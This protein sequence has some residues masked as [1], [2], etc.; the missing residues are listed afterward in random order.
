MARRKEEKKSPFIIRF[1]GGLIKKSIAFL[2]LM[3]IFIGSIV[4]GLYVTN[5]FFAPTPLEDLPYSERV[6]EALMRAEDNV[7]FLL[8]GS[9][10]REGEVSRSDTMI[11]MVV[12]PKDK[13]IAYLSFPRD[14]L[15]SIEGYGEDKLNHAY[16]YGGLP[17]LESTIRSNF[18]AK[19]DYT[20]KVDFNS[21]KKVI[22]AMGGIT[23]DVESD[24]SVPW[25]EIDL[26]KGKQVLNGHDALGYV[27]WRSDG[28]GDLGRIERQQKF[29]QAVTEKL[30]HMM[31]WTAVRVLHTIQSEIET[32]FSFKEM[33]LL[34]G[35][36]VGIGKD[37]IS[38]LS[39]AVEPITIGG[40]S[41][42]R[43]NA[44]NVRQVLEEADYGMVLGD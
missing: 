17:L 4:G 39:F 11:Y 3:A 13:K 14:T 35:R 1:F 18:H 21:F 22:D 9:D 42:V 38:H 27:R 37:D 10:E 40:I 30:Q 34:G 12:R 33:L 29:M 19:I 2:L 15:V 8:V 23:L 5:T 24:M 36:L 44:D 31:P 28:L 26:K 16:A 7:H 32:D 43:Y 25:E 41:Y 20:I 6:S